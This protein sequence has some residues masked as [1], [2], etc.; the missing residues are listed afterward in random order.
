MFTSAVVG[1][2]VA[3]FLASFVEFVEA[4][5]IVL[6]MGMTRS[7]KSAWAGTIAALV[8]LAAFTA[9]AGYAL[10]TWLPEAALQLV[11]GTLL[12]IFGL[13]WLRKAVLRSSGRKALHDEAEEFREQAEAARRAGQQSRFGLDWFAFVVSFK[14]VFLEGVE[15]VFIVITFGLNAQNMP[16]A[17]VGAA[18]AGLIVVVVGAFAHGPLTRVPENTLKYGVGLLLATFGLFWAVEGL[19]LLAPGHHSLDWPGGDWA[20]LV[21]LA[22]WL[23]L[24]RALVAAL[25]RPVAAPHAAVAGAQRVTEEV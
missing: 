6:A 17:I 8:A 1:L 4:L 2:A 24:S 15:V 11:V 20:L 12:L 18:A 9:A 23:L 25:R 13:Q 10:A 3:V 22:V 14:G 21:L 16:V 7:W 19:G 5:T